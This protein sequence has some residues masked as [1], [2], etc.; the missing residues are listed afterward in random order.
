[1]RHE[2]F[3]IVGASARR[4]REERALDLADTADRIGV[5]SEDL[6]LFE[7]AAKRMRLDKLDRLVSVLGVPI[8]SLFVLESGDE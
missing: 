2:V 7:R 1:M 5:S 3:E 8:S 6:E 4:L